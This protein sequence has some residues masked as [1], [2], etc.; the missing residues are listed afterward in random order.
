MVASFHGHRMD[1]ESIRRH[2]PTSLKGTTLRT[3]MSAAARF[4]LASRAL[5]LEPEHLP[6]LRAPAILH[7]NLDHFVVLATTR[8]KSALIH[9][10]ARGRRTVGP[11]ELSENFTGVALELVPTTG[12]EIRDETRRVHLRELI[13]RSAGLWRMLAQIFALSA[14][15]QVFTLLAPFYMQTVVDHT[16]STADL[17]LL[18]ALAVGFCLLALVQMLTAALRAW[19]VLYLNSTLDLHLVSKVFRQLLRLP[20]DW[21]AKRH[22]GDVLSRFGSLRNV[23]ELFTNGLVE[24]I[25]DGFMAS[26]TLTLMVVYSPTLALVSTTAVALYTAA[27]MLLFGASRHYVRDA[28]VL[29]AREQ[30]TF[31]ESLRAIV[32]IKLFRQEAARESRWQNEYAAAL[33][34]NIRSARLAIFYDSINR[35]LFPLASVL[36][37]WLAAREILAAAFSV[38]MLYAFFS[39]QSQFT[40]RA[41]AL[42]DKLFAFRLAGVEMAR[43]SDIVHASP[44]AGLDLGVE[45]G[46]SLTGNIEIKDLTFRYS[47]DDPLMFDGLSFSISSGE[48]VAISGPSGRGKTTLLKLMLGLLDPAAG[49]VR[50]DGLDISR[51]GKDMFRG[52]VSAV[53][54]DD[55]LLSGSIAENISFFDPTPDMEFV[56]QCALRAEIAQDILRMP[57]GYSSRIGDMGSALSGGQRQRVLLARSLYRRPRILFLDEASSHLELATESRINTM[58]RESGIT[59]VVIAHRPETMS[60]ADRVIDLGEPSDGARLTPKPACAA[61]TGDD[62][63][64]Q[65]IREN[66]M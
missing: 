59:R 33:N 19:A 16:I 26:G 47:P 5:R 39:Y 46:R 63:V 1:V 58:L 64:H 50:Y 57:M 62:F 14:A 11:E 13:G 65:P 44:E 38:G 31:L 51:F 34:G 35:T 60:L 37:V 7:W 18:N 2:L 45:Q 12:F 9:D 32:P 40:Q 52:Q 54:Q 43:L 3:L 56:H 23:R 17:P 24:S 28:L 41:V 25:V 30:T 21:F 49:T 36:I 66:Q 48:C 8:G 42:I 22:M 6:N 15:L 53:M 27:R 20:A 29:S 4:G 55:L 61:S 10:P